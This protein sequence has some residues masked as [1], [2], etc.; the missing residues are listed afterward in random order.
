[1]PGLMTRG[2][3]LL[4]GMAALA[5]A[6]GAAPPAAAKPAG[7]EK[8]EHV[9]VLFMENRS[10]DNLLGLFPTAEGLLAAGQIP[11]QVDKDGKPYATLPR[12]INTN[13]KPPVPDDRF[14]ADLPNRPFL[15]E[16][17][18]PID[19]RTGDLV[20]RWYQ[21]QYQIGDG[22]MDRFVAWSDA[23]GLAISYYDGSKLTLWRYAQEYT[24]ADNFFHGAFG[25]SFL[26]HMWLV[27]ACMPK[28]EN[29]PPELVAKLGPDGVMA[30]D[31]PVTP[32]GWAVNTI[33]S[34]Y[35]PHSA[36]ITDTKKLLPP[37]TQ[38]TIGER[39]S[40]KKIGWA[41]YSGGWNDAMA[42]K[43]APSFQFHHQPFAYFQQYA[44]G[45]P[46][47]AEHLKDAEDFFA[48]ID[49]GTL[50]AVAFYKPLGV[51][52]MHPGYADVV[53]GDKEIERVVE[54]VRG[55]PTIWNSSAIIVTYDENG[56]LWDHVAPPKVD[57]YGPG[58]RIPTVVISPYAKHGHV[59]HTF[60][61]TTSV[62]KFIE[63]RFDLAPLSER[64]AKVGDLTNAF[65][66]Y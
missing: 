65:A 20:H 42:G 61:D 47:K 4:G 25:G 23:A 60:Y 28:Y 13:V 37:Q 50:P 56:S 45:T 24:L 8:I 21:E 7:M 18:V 51:E 5:F 58:T 66:F 10:F 26:N 59:D 12:P 36:A 15:T 6:A 35:Q 11:P 29:A 32:E 49:S 22:K 40:E 2:Q 48:A 52:N 9:I 1:M 64:E 57:Q 33:Q 41:Y 43:P 16:A 39:L 63:T 62:L 44:D 19:V 54:K 31:G 3:I 55:N 53:D 30:T 38:T 46:A 14:P 34:A 17:Y 27:C